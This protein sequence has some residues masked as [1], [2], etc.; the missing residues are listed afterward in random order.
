[1]TYVDDTEDIRGGTYL[2]VCEKMKN[3]DPFGMGLVV[4]FLALISDIRR[5]LAPTGS[6]ISFS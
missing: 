2:F 6:S 1:L 5:G 3:A 4:F